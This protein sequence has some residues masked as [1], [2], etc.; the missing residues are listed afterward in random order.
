MK[1]LLLLRHGK[2]DWKNELES[3][4]DRPL[5]PRG[6]KAARKMAEMMEEEDL[7]PELIVSSPAKRAISTA[8]IVL[9]ELGDVELEE[10]EDIYGAELSALMNVVHSLPED[11][12]KVMLVGH[13]PGFEELANALS[14]REDT[15][16]KTCSL[17]ILN[18]RR[19]SWEEVQE[20]S[21][22]LEDIKNPGGKDED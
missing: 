18:M 19:G 17:A 9:D 6:I 22:E 13:N 12:D 1:T 8:R 20:G 15:V 11:Y 3:D 10:N 14:G 5:A 2:S 16:M 7:V 21:F 4:F